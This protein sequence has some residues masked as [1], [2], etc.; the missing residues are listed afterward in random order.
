MY[1]HRVV[2]FAI[3]RK[4]ESIL[5]FETSINVQ[6][7]RTRLKHSMKIFLRATN[8]E[9]LRNYRGIIEERFLNMC[10]L[11]HFESIV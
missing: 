9:L 10:V 6:V 3:E 1:I 11:L 5:V 4:K 2:T 8:S 7:P